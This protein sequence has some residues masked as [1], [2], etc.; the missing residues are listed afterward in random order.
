M[1]CVEEHSVLCTL[2]DL[3]EFEKEDLEVSLVGVRGS[4]LGTFQD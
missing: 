2:I 4:D 1:R 3:A